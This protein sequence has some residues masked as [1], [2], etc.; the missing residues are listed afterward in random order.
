[1]SI[2]TLVKYSTMCVEM[3]PN[4][5]QHRST[6]GKHYLSSLM[7]LVGW[8]EAPLT[9][10][11]YFNKSEKVI[12]GNC[13]TCSSSAVAVGCWIK[14]ERRK[15]QIWVARENYVTYHQH[16]AAYLVDCVLLQVDQDQVTAMYSSLQPVHLNGLLYFAAENHLLRYQSQDAEKESAAAAVCWGRW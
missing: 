10:K 13:L 15:V 6:E 7:L 11:S 12:S 1:M 4:K 14:T 3:L 2:I 5:W 8:Q 16:E 9:C